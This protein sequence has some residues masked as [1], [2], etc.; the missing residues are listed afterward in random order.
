MQPTNIWAAALQASVDVLHVD[1]WRF[2]I[3]ERRSSDELSANVWNGFLPSE[4]FPACAVML[5]RWHSIYSFGFFFFL[6]VSL[7]VCRMNSK[8]TSD[9]KKKKKAAS[10]SQCP[11]NFDFLDFS[12]YPDLTQVKSDQRGNF[13]WIEFSSKMD[14]VLRFIY[15]YMCVCLFF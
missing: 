15:I 7:S 4:K 6:V 1:G 14:F 11:P 3:T 13:R 2:Q 12:L 5:M 10:A 8:E 9:L